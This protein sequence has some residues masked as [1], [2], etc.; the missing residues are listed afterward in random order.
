MNVR[1]RPVAARDIW[2]IYSWRNN[3]AVRKMMFTTRPIGRAE[4][5][6]FW[7]SRLA[8]KEGFS[9]IVIAGGRRCGLVRLDKKGRLHEVDILVSPSMQGRG[10]GRQALAALLSFVRR[11]GVKKVGARVKKS[12]RASQGLFEAGG[13]AKRGARQGYVI[14]G[15]DL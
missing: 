4:H 7:K 11:R 9:F 6:S 13:F 8:G 10:I 15:R 3:P 1:I 5:L 2:A 14:Y 12:N